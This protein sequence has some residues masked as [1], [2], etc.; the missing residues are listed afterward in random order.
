MEN[1][2][3]NNFIYLKLCSI[4]IS[5]IIFLCGNVVNA[6]SSSTAYDI[7][8][9]TIDATVMK[10]GN[11]HI[12][13]KIIFDFKEKA[14][15]VYRDILY[16]YKYNNQKDDMNPSSSR[17]QA[18]DIE[19]I[20][21][22]RTDES[23]SNDFELKK[24]NER[25]A[26]NGMDNVYSISQITE[27]GYLKRIK[28]YEPSISGSKKY[29]KIEY[30]VVTPT[31]LYND[32]GEI[33][34][35]FVGGNWD[36]LIENLKINIDFEQ[37]YNGE[38][39]KFYPHGYTNITNIENSNGKL[40]FFIEKLKA[41]TAVDARVVFSSIYLDKAK[42]KYDT[43]YDYITLEKIEKTMNFGKTRNSISKLLTYV[44]IIITIVYFILLIIK[45]IKISSKGKKSKPEYY[46][47]PLNNLNLSVYTKINSDSIINPNL[48]MAT[49]LDLQNKKAITM[50]AQK[51]LKVSF[52]GIKYNY[53]LTINKDF[54]FKKLSEYELLIINYLFN[55]RASQNVNFNNF[56]EQTIELNEKLKKLSKNY[57]E[58]RKFQSVCYNYDK[59]IS[60][61][62][63]TETDSGLKEFSAFWLI[64]LFVI[65]IIN[66]FVISP[67]NFNLKIENATIYIL[68]GFFITIIAVSLTFVKSLKEEYYEEY[69]KL[70]GLKKYLLEYSLIKDRYPIEIA[71]W[72]RYLVFASLFGI[73]KKVAKEFKEELIANGYDEDYIYMNYPLIGMSMYNSNFSSYVSTSTGSSSS[74]GFSGGGS[75]GGGRWWW[76]EEALSK[77]R[78]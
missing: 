3:K 65:S 42:N 77:S 54:D 4:I 78:I 38:N 34:W 17:Y 47:E 73:A 12:V 31:V 6:D 8:E 25:S 10:N 50:D 18:Q 59:K 28:I 19:N 27:D 1:M 43:S 63:Y 39:I 71:L 40:S 66:V 74:G 15:G 56:K 44:I 69:N 7:G 60:K 21:V 62:V 61:V 57:Y 49:V 48:F 11:L 68:I 23:F 37:E 55:E 36:C 45:S 51:K 13:E 76:P 35:N 16:K 46:T 20:K 14:N 72:D 70:V 5:V 26:L 33:Y 64:F 75:G 32:A 67:L 30:D 22:Y 24:I 58:S 9:Y 52:D 53:Y 29:L 41:G 2:K